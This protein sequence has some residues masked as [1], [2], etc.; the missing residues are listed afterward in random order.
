VTQLADDAIQ[1]AELAWFQT[2][3]E[4]R[5]DVAAKH[6]TGLVEH[7][8]TPVGDDH[9]GNAA[10]RG[11]SDSLHIARSLDAVNDPRDTT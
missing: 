11:M 2:T 10:V 7:G 5:L 4:V 9:V 6:G 8:P 3:D 1:L